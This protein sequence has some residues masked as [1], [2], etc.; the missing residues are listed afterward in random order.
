[1][2]IIEW[3]NKDGQTIKLLDKDE[4]EE[5]CYLINK[6]LKLGKAESGFINTIVEVG[7]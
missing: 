5:L 7:A 1:M 2:E 3:A 4:A 6:A